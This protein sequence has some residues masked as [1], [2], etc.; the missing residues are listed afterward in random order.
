MLRLIG[1]RKGYSVSDYLE[2]MGT[3]PVRSVVRYVI[4][5]VLAGAAIILFFFS[6]LAAVAALVLML[7]VNGITHYQESQKIEPYLSCLSCI[8][9][10]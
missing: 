5:A 1:K 4:Q 2:A 10:C 9:R 7:C 8:L 3:A 6:P